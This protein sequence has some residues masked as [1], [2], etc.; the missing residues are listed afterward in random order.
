MTAVE[1]SGIIAATKLEV[2][3]RRAELVAREALVATLAGAAHTRLTLLSAPPGS[4]KTTLLQQ[5]HRAASPAQRFAWLSLDAGDDDPVRFWT[6]VIE[7][8]RMVAPGFG[9]RAAGAL[10]SPGASLD[11][12]VVALLVNE[13]AQLDG[14]VVL[15]IDDLHVLSDREIH[16][17]LAAFVERLPPTL[18]LAVAT[19]T[20]PPWP[21]LP[22]LRARDEIVEVGA[23]QLRFSDVEAAAYLT[24]LG[25]GLEAAQIADIQQRTEGWAAGLQLAGLSLR[26]RPERD[27]LLEALAGDSRQ[28]RDYLVAEVLE[29]ADPQL[30]RFLLHTA[31]L[32]RMSAGLCDAVTGSGGSATRLAELERR[33]LFVVALD[34]RRRWYRYH[35]LFAEFLREQLAAEEPGATAVL[36][37]RASE[38]LAAEGQ[39]AEAIEHAIAAGDEGRTADLVAAHWL[40]FFNDGWL[41]TVSRWLDALPRDVVA[42]DRR[43]WLARAWTALDHGQLEEVEPW[44]ATASEREGWTEVLRAL[45]RFKTGDVGA[46]ARAA[47]AEE[48]GADVFRRT[49]ARCVIGV[50]AYWRA[51][52]ADARAA[53]AEAARLAAADRN[54]LAHQYAV[55]YLALDAAEHEGA[56]A[57]L[58]L[59]AQRE[60]EVQREPQADEHFTAMMGHLARGRAHELEGLLREAEVELARAAELSRR[61]A[62]LVEQAAAAL[63]HARVLAALGRRASARERMAQARELLSRCADAGTLGRAV[64]EAEHAPGLAAPRAP[65]AAGEALS[66]RELGVLRLLHSELSLREIGAEL[67]LSH[68]TIKTHARNIYL[69]LG[70]AGRDEAVA[71]ARERGLL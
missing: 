68:N 45:H 64:A 3:P 15:V 6:C 48:D 36:H 28:I 39:V 53:L 44:L 52:Y 29:H 43:L 69:K 22:R 27:D 37:A 55:G 50:T 11:A 17:S 51:R 62:G 24:G 57:A 23:L 40:T 26:G 8:L 30:R 41:A 14:R 47:I 35:H 21:L 67:Y 59:M 60:P 33:N 20:V 5:W 54:A 32:D 49:V 71:R 7:A 16:G 61:G 34:R 31:V 63:A 65:A 12:V 1:A 9:A 10:R 38:W 13:L 58:A 18:H 19:R 4:G 25:L 70:A 56:A 66:E 46:A 2:P 42:A